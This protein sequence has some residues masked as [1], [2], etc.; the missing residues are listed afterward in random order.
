VETGVEDRVVFA[1]HVPGMARWLAAFDALAV[2]TK[3]G[4]RRA[5]KREGFGTAAFE[6]ML[7]GVPVIAVAGGAVARRL[8]GR[9][10]IEVPPADPQAVAEALER[11][12]DPRLRAAVGSAGREILASHPSVEECARMLVEV[13]RDAARTRR[14]R[15]QRRRSNTS[16]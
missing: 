12:A 11:L 9:A 2:L 13:L 4:A 5:P 8:E 16:A 14:A 1:G 3:P 10:G 7:A 15:P 6:A